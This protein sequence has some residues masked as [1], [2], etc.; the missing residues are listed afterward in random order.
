MS[1]KGSNLN[2]GAKI[3][4][5]AAL[6]AASNPLRK[7]II[8][9]MKEG[10]STTLDL[11]EKTNENRYNIQHHLKVLEDNKLIKL[12]KKKS[13]GKI[14][15]YEM[16]YVDK[17]TIAAF[18]FDEEDIKEKSKQ[19]NQLYKLLQEM[20]NYPIPKTNISKIEVYITYDWSK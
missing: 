13:E 4:I 16:N 10:A 15:Y 6:S 14:Q 17:P 20:E 9:Y 11:V 7:K 19:C 3:Y 8:K 2:K 5:Q 18:S 1:K 12:N